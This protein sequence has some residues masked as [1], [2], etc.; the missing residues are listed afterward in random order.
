MTICHLCQIVMSKCQKRPKG[1]HCRVKE[2][3]GLDE[4]IMEAGWSGLDVLSYMSN[5]RR[6]CFGITVGLSEITGRPIY[7]YIQL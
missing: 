4:G 7:E 2:P 6:Q 1:L 3:L 5:L